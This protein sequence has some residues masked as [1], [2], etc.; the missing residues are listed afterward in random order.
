MN[1]T[2]SCYE[3][4]ASMNRRSNAAAAMKEFGETMLRA[5]RIY[6]YALT[7]MNTTTA[8]VRTADV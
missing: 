2:D 7:A 3:I 8:A 1:L 5:M 6:L 4:I